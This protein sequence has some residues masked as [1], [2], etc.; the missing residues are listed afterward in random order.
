MTEAGATLHQGW[1]G[2]PRGGNSI[3]L[4]GWL[5]RRRERDSDYSRPGVN[6]ARVWCGSHDDQPLL[7]KLAESDTDG[8]DADLGLTGQG[9][10]PE[11]DAG[12]E[13]VLRRSP[14]AVGN[15][16]LSIARPTTINSNNQ[17]RGVTQ[18]GGCPRR[19]AVL[20]VWRPDQV[21][22]EARGLRCVL[23]SSAALA[24]ECRDS[25]SAQVFGRSIGASPES[26]ESLPHLAHSVR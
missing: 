4:A 21:M 1:L 12:S 19:P 3:G 20:W 23:V 15:A 22:L 24:A 14:V 16:G 11:P 18:T 13:G 10:V 8:R 26:G 25:A 6:A 17:T 7:G 2:P 9:E 5:R